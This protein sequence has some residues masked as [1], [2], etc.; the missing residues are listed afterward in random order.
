L[1]SRLAH[2]DFIAQH[3]TK[4]TAF[5]RTRKLPFQTLCLF[6]LN[7]VKGASQSE[8]DDFFTVLHQ[9]DE[10][11]RFITASAFSQAR[12]HLKHTAF[13]ALN[14]E[15][16]KQYYQLNITKRWRGHRL[17]AV[18]S[19][20]LRLPESPALTDYFGG[21]VNANNLVTMARLSTCF[22]I[23]SGLTIDAQIAPYKD[24][25]RDLAANHLAKT[26]PN[27]VL[28]YDRGYPAFWL[29]ALHRGLNRDFCMR[30]ST[31]WS[32]S[33][34]EFIAS[35]EVD[36]L[37][38]F[39]P[40]HSSKTQ[41]NN[42]G[43]SLEPFLLRVL[44]IALPTGET[45]ILFTTLL[46]AERYPHEDF[47]DLYGRRWGIEV[48]Y[49]FKKNKLEIENFTGLSVHAIKQDIAAKVLTHNIAMAAASC[50]QQRVKKRYAH[51]EHAY[52]INVSHGL[53]AMKH[54]LVKMVS[55]GQFE[56]LFEHYIA[57]LLDTVC[58]VRPGRSFVRSNAKIRKIRFYI[59]AKR[60]R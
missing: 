11:T 5:T 23:S 47:Y 35:S 16:N 18:D 58:A 10:E 56:R 9:Q 8:L 37:I 48:D 40:N 39:H 57:L 53:S 12:E 19:S 46:D 30:A 22:D 14:A 7:L 38:E 4:P 32:P 51:R 6:L 49:H 15:F 29:F 25:E 50:A 33:I 27:D 26:Q 20:T 21:Q 17:L 2:P 13:E 55:R 41:C 60:A 59:S 24:S 52:K 36:A 31:A 34:E 28:I 42:L 45:E 54:L 1:Y 44:K 3:R 43:L